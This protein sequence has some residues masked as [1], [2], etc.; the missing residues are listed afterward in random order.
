MGHDIPRVTHRT[1]SGTQSEEWYVVKIKLIEGHSDMEGQLLCWICLV[2]LRF[3]D[4]PK[5]WDM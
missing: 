2:R 1:L 5:A 4:G 3:F